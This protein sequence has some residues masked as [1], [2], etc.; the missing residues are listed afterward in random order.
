MAPKLVDVGRHPNIDLITYSELQTVKGTEGKYTVTIKKK[1]R[2][3]DVE[4]CTG[5]GVCAQQC[6]IDAINVFNEGLSD[7]RCIY[8]P[9]PQAVPLAYTIDREKCIGCGL[10]EN[11]CLADAITYDDQ[12]ETMDLTVGSIILCPGFDEFESDIKSEYGHDRYENVL[13]SIEFERVLSASGPYKGHILRPSDGKQPKKV[14]WIQCVGSRDRGCG[15]NYCSSVCCTYAIKEAVIAKEH[16]STIEPTIFYM[17]MRTFGKGFEEYYNRAQEEHGVRFI[18]CRIPEIQ[19]D[20]TTKNLC[21]RYETEDGTFI[22]EEFDLVVLSVGFMPKQS[23]RQLA[24]VLDIQLNEYGFCQTS[25][26]TPV[27]TSKPGIYVCG[28]FSGPKDIPETV[29]EASGAAITAT[30]RIA[31]ARHTLVEKKKYPRERQIVG[32]DPRI[33]VFICHCGINIGA[34]VDVPAVVD[35]AKTLPGVAHAEENLYTCS[36]DTQKKIVETIKEH[37]L[38]RVIVASCTPRTH[39]PLFQST[40]REA[41]LNPHLF[42]MANIRDQCSWAHMGDK[43][44][45]TEKAKTLVKM[46]V[47]KASLIEPLSEITLQVTQKALIIG[48]GIAGMT[49]ALSIADQGY[50][51]FLVE[52]EQDLGGVAKKIHW[53]IEQDDVQSYLSTTI[54]KVMDHENIHVY[55][56]ATVQSIEGYIGNYKTTIQN[57]KTSLEI[58]HGVIIVAT[59][60][61]ESTPKEY[62]YGKDDRVMTQLEFEHELA[63]SK[64]FK[65][66]TIVMIQCVGSRE[67]D[68]P[69]CSRIC[70]IDAVKNAITLKQQHPEVSVYVLYRDIRTYGLYEQFYEK[71]RELGVIFIRYDVEKK[72]HVVKGK[73]T[74]DITIHDKIINDD[75]LLHADVLVLSPAILP[76]ESNTLIAQQLKVPLNDN[77]FFLEAHVKLRPVDF[78]TEGVF[79]AGM[80]HSPKTISETI[81]QAYAAA[82]RA[83]TILSSD[84]YVTEAVVSS[85]NEDLCC[86]CGICETTCSYGAIERQKRMIDGK[87][88][89]IAHVNEG[90][91]KGCGSCAS[92]CPSGAIEQKGFKKDQI[93]SMIDAAMQWC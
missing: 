37:N 50:E 31:P 62:L 3:V 53:T 92:A 18:R 9:Y 5:C 33:G 10:C 75:L 88:K 86:G 29:M 21:I 7:R 68:R 43:P 70:C 49:A 90:L 91:C 35:Y 69:Y 84:T 17:D 1:A 55:T 39:E 80:A 36:Q 87:E 20:E 26:F 30:S 79:L 13:T 72:P 52:R 2:Y 40:I 38:N 58:T 54:K 22:E 71:A 57:S 25:R 66:K 12:E 82:S 11:L 51:V 46:A 24:N 6:P 8:V 48:G 34:Y 28:S 60:A 93:S 81:A 4:K 67:K 23:V 27:S 44:H 77:G 61:I 41:G 78:A 32:E 74:L 14:A 59:G 64:E 76:A 65:G 19:E 42:E 16:V 47:A 56:K 89:L 45:A 15:N 73:K 83:M 63:E 85:V